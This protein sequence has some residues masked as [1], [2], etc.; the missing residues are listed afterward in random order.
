MPKLRTTRVRP[1]AVAALVAGAVCAAAGP[2]MAAGSPRTAPAAAQHQVDASHVA[3]APNA[4]GTFSLLNY[5]SWQQGAGN[6]KCIGIAS[7]G[8]AGDWSCTGNP[9]QTWHWGGSKAQGNAV[10]W[11]LVNG[12]GKCLGVA[13][14]NTQQAAQIVGWS[15]LGTGHPDQ[16]WAFGLSYYSGSNPLINYSG[17]VAGVGGGSLANGAPLV[18]WSY[19]YAPDQAWITN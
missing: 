5:K 13:G 16:Y 15:C 3:L 6:Y 1:L 11:Q 19:T 18:L 14:G 12:N 8:N 10:Y 7:N 17:Y 2:A 4:N 9:D